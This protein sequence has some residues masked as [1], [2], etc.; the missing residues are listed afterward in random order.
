M[1]FA[2]HLKGWSI[3]PLTEKNN[4]MIRSIIPLLLL[5]ALLQ[6]CQPEESW[7]NEILYASGAIK[8]M[9]SYVVKDGDTII[10]GQK[11]FHENG[12][13]YMMGKLKDKERDGLWKT[14]YEDGTPWSETHFK[15]GIT[16]GSTKTWYKNRKVRFTGFYTDGEKSGT[17]YWYNE[18]G[19]LNKKIELGE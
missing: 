9:E 4:Q 6:A 7:K 15:E 14:Y 18:E 3:I 8:L 1:N 19:K 11:V 16:D 12:Q 13:V 5:F 17:W 2:I 10:T